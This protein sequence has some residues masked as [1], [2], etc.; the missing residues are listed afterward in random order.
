[1]HLLKPAKPLYAQYYAFMR[2]RPCSLDANAANTRY[3]T[4]KK[5]Q[6]CEVTETPRAV[7]A[8]G[9]DRGRLQKRPFAS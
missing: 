2:F 6:S 9:Y 4:S 8:V 3:C 5:P 7:M 1:M